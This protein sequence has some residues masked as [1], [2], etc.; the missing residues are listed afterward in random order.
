MPRA[1]VTGAAGQVGAELRASCPAG[2][3]CTAVDRATLDITDR[4]A[5]LDT[6]AR[7]KPALI[8]NAAAYTAVDKAETERDLAFKVNAHAPGHLAEAA[9]KHGARL[10][11]ISTDYVFDGTHATPYRPGDPTCPV[12]TYG[13]SKLDGERA[14]LERTGG[15]ALVVRTAWVYNATGKNFVNTMLRLMRERDEVRVVCDQVGTPT[16]AAGLASALWRLAAKPEARGILH[17]TDA[18]VAS[19]Y[20]F[21]EAIRVAAASSRSDVRWGRVIP[22]PTDEFPTPARRPACVILDKTKTWA[23]LG[24]PAGAWTS[25][26]TAIVNARARALPA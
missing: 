9:A 14:V 25:A 7:V 22:I 4:A 5:V 19:W 13:A 12:N 1:L 6:V 21:A 2:W 16:H 26:V 17:W 20:D 23:L 8:V 18:G 3:D 15:A 24:A 11:H 10:I